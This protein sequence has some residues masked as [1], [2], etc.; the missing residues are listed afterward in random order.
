MINSHLLIIG[1]SANIVYYVVHHVCSIIFELNI[2][3]N[4]SASKMFNIK[5]IIIYAKNFFF[6]N[7]IVKNINY[8]IMT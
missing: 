6:H 3:F 8:E 2:F 4:T 1:I 5:I 7:K